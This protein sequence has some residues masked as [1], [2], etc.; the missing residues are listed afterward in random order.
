[1]IG[2]NRLNFTVSTP[3]VFT[4]DQYRFSAKNTLVDPFGQPIDGNANGT[5]GDAFMRSFTI[6]PAT[7][8]YTVNLA[9]GQAVTNAHF[10][11]HDVVGPRSLSSVLAYAT[12][13][14]RITVQFNEDVSGTLALG[15]LS[16]QNLTTGLPVNMG[17]YS[18]AYD[19]GTNTATWNVNGILPDARFRGTIAAS[20]V[21]DRSGN[22]LDGDGN[23]T[24][25]DDHVFDFFFLMGDANHDARVN[26]DD[27]NIL[28]TNF[29]QSPRDFTQG[30]FTYDN[31]VN[32][33]DFNVLASKF[34]SILAGPSASPSNGR[35]TSLD[36]LRDDAD[37]LGDLL[38]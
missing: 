14:H 36:D 26:L 13:P 6:L 22:A 11:N 16:L 7:N 12:S 2:T 35:T 21:A 33:D 3:G 9:D 1:M 25:G 28:A 37:P 24:G 20:G 34:G 27:F 29:G 4:P 17:S 32:L 19:T 5:G 31:Q 10:G 23:G 38:A 15:D 30:D 8:R 18:F